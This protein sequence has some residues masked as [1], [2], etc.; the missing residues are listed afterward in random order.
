MCTF[1]PRQWSKSGS[2]GA[3]EQLCSNSARAPMP[4]SLLRRVARRLTNLPQ[5]TTIEELSHQSWA[6]GAAGSALPWHGRGRRFDPDQ[7][8]QFLDMLAVYILESQ[9][10]KRFYI[11]SAVDTEIRLA[12]HERGQTK[13]TRGRGPWVPVYREAFDTIV[14]ARRRELQLNS[15][16]PH[17]AIQNLI[18]SKR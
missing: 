9:T 10:N 8:H 6:C 1:S 12:E 13:S 16:K 18:D 4:R 2:L 5:A 3:W 14:E 11:G 15:W 7:V 17:R